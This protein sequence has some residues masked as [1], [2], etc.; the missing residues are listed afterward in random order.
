MA[1]T[2]QRAVGMIHLGALVTRRHEASASGDGVGVEVKGHGA[3]LASEIGD[4]DDV[5]AGDG[6][7]QNIGSTHHEVGQ[8][9][10][11]LENLLGFGAAIVIE[12]VKDAAQIST[13]MMAGWGLLGPGEQLVQGLAA[14]DDL[15]LGNHLLQS[16]KPSLTHA[17]GGGGLA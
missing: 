14:T 6:Q 8:G 17:V 1:A 16:L 3:E 7:E 11:Q 13:V 2:A 5:D 12:S 15:V 9:P 4:G 10:L